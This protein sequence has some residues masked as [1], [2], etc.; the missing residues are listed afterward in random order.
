M[1]HASLAALLAAAVAA[2]LGCCVPGREKPAEDPTPAAK[3]EPQPQP[4]PP[5][6]EKVA[7]A[8]KDSVTLGNLQASVTDIRIGRPRIKSIFSG[9]REFVSKESR[10]IV[11]FELRNLSDVKQVNHLG[12]SRTFLDDRAKLTDEHGN[13]YFHIG[14]D[15]ETVDGI[16]VMHSV[17]RPS[18]TARDLAMFQTP[19]DK[20]TDFRLSLPGPDGGTF[21]F[22]FPIAL[23]KRD[24]AE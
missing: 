7:V 9:E 22:Q 20:A 18:T 4:Q 24:A 17:I 11:Y 19:V 3:I 10:L 23:V 15:D 21:R 13:S 2:S 14:S 12:W 8:T 5:P 6:V 1:R 16:K